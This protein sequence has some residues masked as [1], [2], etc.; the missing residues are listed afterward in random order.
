MNEAVIDSGALAP[1]ESATP[2]VA[3]VPLEQVRVPEGLSSQTPV[4]DKPVKV[5][6][7]D[8]AKPTVADA[9]N[10]AR[11]Q[12]KAREAEKTAKP[13]PAKAV[14]KPEPETK[15]VEAR[16]RAP[17]GKFTPKEQP[18]PEQVAQPVQ[19]QNPNSPHREAP[20]RFSPDAKAAWETAPEP[21]KAE[22]HRAIKE[23]EQGH[24]KYRESADAYEQVRPFDEMA[25]KNGGNL[26]ASLER[27]VEME[28]AFARDPIEGFH[29]VADHFGLSLRAIAAHIMGQTPDAV[30]QQTDTTVSS[31][32]NEIATLKQQLSGVTQ[33]IEKQQQSAL[34]SHVQS[35]A[36]EHPRLDDLSDDIAMF[37]K[38]ERQIGGEFRFP[39]LQEAY[40]LA[41][42]LNPAPAQAFA[43]AAP[44]IPPAKPTA[45][46]LN[47]AGQKSITGAPTNGSNPSPRK[48]AAPSIR[49]ALRQASA[50]HR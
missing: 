2:S 3:E 13:E 40:E 10:K 29:A 24:Q 30:Q 42:R 39:T 33:T 28:N 34:L 35:F 46:P 23:L 4:A 43:P 31:L 18:A 26:K 6:I 48:S 5:E 9:L 27:V 44:V 12:V 17:D 32:K 11:E 21:V 8:K 14:E 45:Q 49:D 20:S 15:P 16:E 38:T 37:L 50:H 25:R 22:V 41:E 47:Q 36:V 1:A 7:A 19:Q